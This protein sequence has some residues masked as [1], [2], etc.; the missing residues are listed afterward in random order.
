MQACERTE[1]TDVNVVSHRTYYNTLFIVLFQVSSPGDDVAL[2][3]ADDFWQ[4]H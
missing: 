1:P 4:Y 2:S 3:T